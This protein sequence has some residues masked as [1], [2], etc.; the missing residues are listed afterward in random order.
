MTV[1]RTSDII[2]VAI[3]IFSAAITYKVKY[4]AQKRSLEVRHI[5]RRIEAEKDT[6]RLLHADWALMTQPVRLQRLIQQYKEELGL[7][8][9]QPEQFIRITDIPVQTL[10]II[11]N[12]IH[13]NEVVI[14]QV[15]LKGKTTRHI[16][17]GRTHP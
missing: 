16:R 8:I 7:E 6:I 17:T 13:D 1:F 2:L 3:M 4:E 14:I 15:G 10:D 5:E 9:I 12:I 11:Q